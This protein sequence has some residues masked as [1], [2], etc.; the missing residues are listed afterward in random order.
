M[1]KKQKLYFVNKIVLINHIK[2]DGFY[3]NIAADV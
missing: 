3:L 2:T 1:K